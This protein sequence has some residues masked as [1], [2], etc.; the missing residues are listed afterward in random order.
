MDPQ[1]WFAHQPAPPESLTAV[2]GD[3]YRSLELPPPETVVQLG[4]PWALRRAVEHLQQ[5]DEAGP[6]LALWQRL[7]KYG[8]HME[9][10]PL[11]SRWDNSV[12]GR[13]FTCR[14]ETVARALR[15]PPEPQAWVELEA[16]VDQQLGQVLQQLRLP[17]L[18][19]VEPQCV[20]LYPLG[21]KVITRG[22]CSHEPI[23]WSLNLERLWGVLWAAPSLQPQPWVEPLAGLVRAGGWIALFDHVAL[24][25][26]GPQQPIAL[27]LSPSAAQHNNLWPEHWSLQELPHQAEGP[28]LTW[29][30]GWALW[31][32]FG[33]PMAR[34][35]LSTC[36]LKPYR[37]TRG[38]LPAQA[39]P[40][41]ESVS[42]PWPL[43]SGYWPSMPDGIYF[44]EYPGGQL[45]LVARARKGQLDSWLLL[46]DGDNT[47]YHG[48]G[49]YYYRNGMM[50]AFG[51]YAD[52]DPYPAPKPFAAWV[53]EQLDK[54]LS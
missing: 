17:S 16:R 24:L 35:E 8:P 53:E 6:M 49:F 43:R 23:P 25:A 11:Q 30:D 21:I 15:Q 31:A 36:A 40:W 50:E 14:C 52:D 29:P 33:L 54:M 10:S 2:V 38:R 39:Q 42:R 28:A 12:M 1:H 7:R 34:E 32:W 41:P 44:L 47:A 20:E 48:D 3:L 26:S 27:Q 4:S 51:A 22:V 45:S 37:L 5:V 9:R 13:Q 18:R 46:A 19:A